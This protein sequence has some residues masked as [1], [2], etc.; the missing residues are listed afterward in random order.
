MPNSS[1]RWAKGVGSSSPTKML[2]F[3]SRQPSFKAFLR[4]RQ[5][6]T[7]IWY[8]A[9]DDLSTANIENNAA[10]RAGLAGAGAPTRG[11]AEA[12]LARL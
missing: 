8:S 9:Y 4:N 12:W 3:F 6:P 1:S 5:L 2:P 10:I 11:Q 7:Q